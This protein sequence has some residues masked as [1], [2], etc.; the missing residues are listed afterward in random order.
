MRVP[1]LKDTKGNEIKPELA[2]LVVPNI[3]GQSNV[4][5]INY[6]I[7]DLNDT[8]EGIIKFTSPINMQWLE[9]FDEE[10]D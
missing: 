4:T 8:G 5:T 2:Y 3:D 7:T 6:T 1:F 10:S 9:D